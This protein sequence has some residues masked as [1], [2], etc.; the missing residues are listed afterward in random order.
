MP[1]ARDKAG[2]F[3]DFSVAFY[4]QPGVATALLHLQDACDAD[5]NVMLLL[6]H[7][8]RA[9][10]RLDPADVAR[11]DAVAAP[12]RSG[13]V[14]PLRGVR[15]RLKVPVGVVEPTASAGLRCAVQRIELAAE[16]LQQQTLESLFPAGAI[17]SAASDP[18]ACARANLVAYGDC[19]GR[20][21]RKAL[22][23]VLERFAAFLPQMREQ[24]K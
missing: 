10:R 11:I 5:V 2:S 20:L 19:V 4:A 21:E 24:G 15:R 18:V 7:L 17:G 14:V 13:V 16:K 23:T 3:W 9:G 6:L 22:A 1:R 12:W 8:A